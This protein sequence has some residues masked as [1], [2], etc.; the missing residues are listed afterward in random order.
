MGK[1]IIPELE[2]LKSTA[3]P[4]LYE[5]L[6][7]VV[8]AINAVPIIKGQGEPNGEVA[9]LPGTLYIPTDP[10]LGES[11]YQKVS[12]TDENGWAAPINGLSGLLRLPVEYTGSTTNGTFTVVEEILLIPPANTR[13]LEF[14][15]VVTGDGAVRLKIQGTNIYSN[16]LAANGV[17]TLLSIPNS[18][19]GIDIECMANAATFSATVTVYAN[20]LISGDQVTGSRADSSSSGTGASG[21][22]G[23]AATGTP[24]GMP[25]SESPSGGD[26]RRFFID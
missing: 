19:R 15:V 16:T 24:S 5:T 17:L 22:T 3:E 14:N 1:L 20:L 11:L 23:G 25:P 26:P 2:E 4:Y 18:A 13:K 12:G 6:R 7:K 10:L 9:A 8:G 21:A